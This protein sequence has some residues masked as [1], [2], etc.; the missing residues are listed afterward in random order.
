M[1]SIADIIRR[2]RH[3]A[4]IADEER[5]RAM[6]FIVAQQAKFSVD[7]EE[8]N[9]SYRNAEGRLDRSERILKLLVRAGVR[10]R[11]KMREQD[12]RFEQRFSLITTTLATLAESQ[13]HTDRRLDALIDVVKEG[14]NGKS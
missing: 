5:Q 1:L 7:I 11:R 8:L 12:D 2:E 10:A 13:V 6:D 4:P 14:R 3:D 9:E